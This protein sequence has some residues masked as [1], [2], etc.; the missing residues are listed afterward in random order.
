MRI[1]AGRG[2]RSVALAQYSLCA[3]LL[4]E[5]LGILPA[6]ETD[7]LYEQILRGELDNGPTV[8]PPPVVAPAPARPTTF[9]FLGRKLD[10][11]PQHNPD[12]SDRQQ[13]RLAGRPPGSGTAAS[14]GGR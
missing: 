8:T 9:A 4:A 2:E 3:R 10:P 1:F 6:P 12:W 7:Q 14:G 5:E 11:F 13:S